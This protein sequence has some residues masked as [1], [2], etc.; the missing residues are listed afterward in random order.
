M[1]DYVALD[2]ETTGLN[3]LKDTIIGVGIYSPKG[4][5]YI[6]NP[7]CKDFERILHT[8]GTRKLVLHNGIFDATFIYHQFNIDLTP[9]IGSD[10]MLLQHTINETKEMSLDKMAQYHLG[11]DFHKY[12]EIVK[13]SVLKNGG[14]YTKEKKDIY[15]ADS[16]I[17][18]K[19]CLRDCE[20]TYKL[21]E[22]LLK[23]FE[24]PLQE[25]LYFE[26]VMPLYT[27]VTIPM[28]YNGICVDVPYF[29]N[30]KKELELSIKGLEF[31][32]RVLIADDVCILEEAILDDSFMLSPRGA[33]GQAV[34]RKYGEF[35]V[36]DRQEEL[37]LKQQLWEKKTGLYWKFNLN[38]NKQ[39]AWLLFDKY[40]EKPFKTTTSGQPSVDAKTLVNYSHVPF[41]N[42]LLELRKE[43][44]LLSTYVLPILEKQIDGKI[45]ADFNQ[46]GTKSGRY[47]LAKDTL[48]E[49]VRDV[50]KFPK[51]VPIQDVKKGEYV[52]TY[53]E[54][55]NLT[56]KKVIWSGKTGTKKV[57]KVHWKGTGNHTKGHLI[58][59]ENHE[60]RL[61][62]GAYRR[63]SDLNIGDSILSM[64]RSKSRGYSRIHYF[65][66][67]EIKDHTFI[68]EQLVGK[69]K[70]H[71][72]HKDGNKL[73]NSINNILEM[74]KRDHG[75]LHSKKINHSPEYFRKIAKLR[76]DKRGY[77]LP[78]KSV[79]R[80]T[81]LR[82]L[83]THRGNLTKCKKIFSDFNTLKKYTE[84]HRID[85]NL[86]K[87]RY[88]EHEYLSRGRILK[89]FIENKHIKG[90]V[91]DLKIGHYKALK[92]LRYYGVNNHKIT[93]IE[94]LKDS[95]EVYDLEVEDTHNFIANNLCVHNSSSSPNMQNL[96]SKD[97]RIRQGIVAPTGY[98]IV[99]SDFDG[100]EPHCFAEVSGCTKL[101]EA[102]KKGE[103][104]YSRAA[105]DIFNLKDVSASPNDP[106][107]L[108]KVNPSY[109]NKMKE[110]CLAVVYGIGKNKLAGVLDVSKT[111]AQR[112]ID[113]YLKIY[114]EL[115][116]Y[117]NTQEEKC[118]STGIISTRY[119]RIRHV[120][121]VLS[122]KRDL[123]D[124]A[125]WKL[126]N[127]L[128]LSKNHPIQGLGAHICNQAMIKFAKTCEYPI[129]Q[130]VH[131]EIVVY[132]PE[133]DAPRVAKLLQEAM[134]NNCITNEMSVPIT[135][136][137]IICSNLKEAK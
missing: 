113:L 87:S 134:E 7:I 29:E 61:T 116:G 40:G 124:Q 120:P 48:I 96:P 78:M 2:I 115:K 93:K 33:Y 12:T 13:Q 129:V 57:L 108:K 21:N 38:S 137:P 111:E 94:Y 92:L 88:S 74:S 32:I 80:M 133:K 24:N 132:A 6:E 28:K 104:L 128:N 17:I 79:N 127:Y 117:M 10:T 71:L 54:N 58:C 122:L 135:A 31:D 47:C 90:F 1:I 70:E 85:I 125:Y 37:F 67:N 16:E 43:Q 110:F 55:L 39:I 69:V 112:I 106:N 68:Y 60:L 35:K 83:A 130:Q 11:A 82:E 19:Y 123:S 101:I 89:S 20:L 52:Y 98:K 121:E 49:T 59:T 27:L 30:L 46:W 107:Y 15:L 3:S 5:I 8:L 73:N 65:G 81:L 75:L 44:K 14:K 56:L 26:E 77:K 102:Y 109:R 95:V 126:R 18:K 114:P 64:S 36:V 34:K 99:D 42:K 66:N 23:E 53:D 72:H 91:K 76:K 50:S 100:I 63:A 41:V 25:K 119:G 136:V 9:H 22:K 131:D 118:L 51:G 62:S 105:I 4:Q 45:Y 103:D 97:M 84:H 86:I